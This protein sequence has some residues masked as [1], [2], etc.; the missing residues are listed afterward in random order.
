M[1]ACNAALP[2]GPGTASPERIARITYREALTFLARI[3]AARPQAR[4]D[5]D[6]SLG[7]VGLEGP[8]GGIRLGCWSSTDHVEVE[9]WHS[10]GRCWMANAPLQ[11]A[12]KAILA[13]PR[14]DQVFELLSTDACDFNEVTET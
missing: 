12:Q 13:C 10:S 6:E 4:P 11:I 7:V 9:L 14:L 3:E 8:D 5:A 2:S 1:M